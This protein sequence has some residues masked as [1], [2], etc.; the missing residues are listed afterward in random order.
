MIDTKELEE[1]VRG[2]IG[3]GATLQEMTSRMRAHMESLREEE[4]EYSQKFTANLRA[5]MED[6]ISRR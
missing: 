5:A 2:I 3:T 6:A 1:Q 4:L